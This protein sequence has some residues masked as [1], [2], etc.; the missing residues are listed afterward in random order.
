[1]SYIY[2]NTRNVHPPPPGHNIYPCSNFD[3]VSAGSIIASSKQLE[4][5]RAEWMDGTMML[6]GAPYWSEMRQLAH[7]VQFS[8]EMLFLEW[9]VDDKGNP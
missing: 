5:E 3:R 8:V 1:M 7:R 6:V 2:K 4:S 9:L